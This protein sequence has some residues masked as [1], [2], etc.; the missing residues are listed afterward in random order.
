MWRVVILHEALKRWSVG[1]LRV[2]AETEVRIVWCKKKGYAQAYV[3][4]IP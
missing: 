3:T 4:L 2:F 1:G